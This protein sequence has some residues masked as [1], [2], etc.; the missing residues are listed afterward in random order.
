LDNGYVTYSGKAGNIYQYQD[1]QDAGSSYALK[2]ATGWLDINP[3]I[4]NRVKVLKRIES[5]FSM[6]GN[7]AV[8]WKWYLDFNPSAYSMSK[9]LNYPYSGGEWNVGEWG[10]A[11]FGGQYTLVEP[12]IPARGDGQFLKLELQAVLNDADMAIQ[13]MQIF[14]KIGRIT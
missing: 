3:Q 6:Y 7:I 14:S 5:I 2:F 8:T 1:K 4:E 9:T 13:Q 10:L 11:E 12:E